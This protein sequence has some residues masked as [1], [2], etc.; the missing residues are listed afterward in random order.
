MLSRS[1]LSQPKLRAKVNENNVQP[2]SGL[3]QE[4]RS[5]GGFCVKRRGLTDSPSIFQLFAPPFLSVALLEPREFVFDGSLARIEGTGLN[6]LGRVDPGLFAGAYVIERSFTNTTPL[7][8]P[9]AKNWLRFLYFVTTKPTLVSS[10]RTFR[11]LKTSGA[12]ARLELGWK[13]GIV[14]QARG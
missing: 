6:V 11:L 8:S 1:L 9:A 13:G 5:G 7:F 3:L 14:Y 10:L 12:P 2:S 4:D